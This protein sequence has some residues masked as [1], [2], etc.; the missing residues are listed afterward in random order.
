MQASISARQSVA[1]KGLGSVKHMRGNRVSQAVRSSAPLR[2]QKPVVAVAEVATEAKVEVKATQGKSPV[3]GI[4][5]TVLGVIL[6]GGA[7]TRLYPLTKKRA[8]P[9]VPLGANYRLIDIPVSN[10]I[11]SGVNKIYC[12][13][14]FNSA[15]LNRHLSQAY[16]ANVGGYMDKGFVE[17][18]AAQQ[19]PTNPNWFQGTADAVRQYMWLFE[20]AMASG[21]EDFLILSGDH[22]YRMDYSDFVV[23]HRAAD[24]AITVAAL[25]CAEKQAQAFG[26]MK[27][28]DSGRI[29][30]FAEK[31]KGEALEA[32]KIDTTVLGLS[33]DRAKEMPYLASMGIYVIK[34]PLLKKLLD[35]NPDSNDFGS[36]V[37]PA[38]KDQGE[39]IQAYLFDGYW[40]D[41]GTI[42]AFY[43]ANLALT[44]T[45][46]PKF[47][48]YDREAPI[49]TM[50][51]FLP[52]SKVL[53][54]EVSESIIGDGCLIRANAK[55]THSVIGLR[56]LISENVVIEDAMIMGSDYYETVEEC[57]M[58]PGCLPMGIGPNSIVKK[59]IIDKNA[60][61]GSNCQIINKDNVMEANCEDQGYLI[62]D[63][64]IVVCKDAIIPDGTII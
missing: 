31:P 49:Y 53:D 9:A 22:L 15:S 8:K 56:A 35:E 59:A 47:S 63:G 54:A 51:R 28:D 18:L 19:S 23:A 57:Q 48:F 60:R 44:D 24:A 20:E 21:M 61:I 10:C 42:E 27:I 2:V 41:I 39:K 32:M 25:P 11:N 14:Q 46:S 12:L 26:L 43:N 33:A 40:E 45:K 30:E 34:A 50:S 4:N 1:P 37:I 36:E 38:A 55:I 5:K 13:T 52:P 58:V 17:V 64:I 6:G 16:N 7:G 62:K 29:V 3:A